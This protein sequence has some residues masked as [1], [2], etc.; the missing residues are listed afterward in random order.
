MGRI[1]TASYR[2]HVEDFFGGAST[3]WS[4][5]AQSKGAVVKL[6]EMMRRLPQ[7]Y[8]WE[9]KVGGRWVIKNPPCKVLADIDT[10]N[11]AEWKNEVTKCAKQLQ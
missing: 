10:T 6:R 5:S 4:G 9:N 11:P 3:K 2:G 8:R 7:H 1:L